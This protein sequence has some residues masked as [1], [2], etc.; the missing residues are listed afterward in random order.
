M[1]KA[2]IL[3]EI[4]NGTKVTEASAKHGISTHTI[5]ARTKAAAERDHDK[6]LKQ[7]RDRQYDISL[8]L[9]EYTKA[10]ENYAVTAATVLN[11]AKNAL[12]HFGFSEVDEK[13]AILGFLLQNCVLVGK[14]LKFDLKKPFDSIAE[15]AQKAVSSGTKNS[16]LGAACPTWLGDLDSN[17]DK[18]LQRLL[19]Y[20]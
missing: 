1:L 4:K 16:A 10:D 9:E 11:L 19:S 3:S 18:Q 12:K 5:Y 20:H 14:E 17:Q 2:Q 7:L 15:A 13:R 8:Q 6:K